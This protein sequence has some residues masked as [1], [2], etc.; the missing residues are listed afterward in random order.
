MPRLNKSTGDCDDKEGGV[1]VTDNGDGVTGS[2]T[3]RI[4]ST[5]LNLYIC[6]RSVLNMSNISSVTKIQ[7]LPIGSYMLLRWWVVYVVYKG[8]NHP[9]SFLCREFVLVTIFS[10]T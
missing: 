2:D 3:I 1:V 7:S 9:I 10:V 8:S 4:M 6:V 5:E